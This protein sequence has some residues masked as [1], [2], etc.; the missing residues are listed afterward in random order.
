[1]VNAASSVV[2]NAQ[3]VVNAVLSVVMNTQGVIKI[4]RFKEITKIYQ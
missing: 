1:M 4:R 2:M 3:A